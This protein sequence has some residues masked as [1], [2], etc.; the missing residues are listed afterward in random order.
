MPLI[1][2]RKKLAPA[3]PVIPTDD[4]GARL[5]VRGDVGVTYAT[6]ALTGWTNQVAGGWPNG[7]QTNA[8]RRPTQSTLNGRNCPL[9]AG[10]D[11]SVNFI[12]MNVALPTFTI[13]I[14]SYMTSVAA[15]QRV[16]LEMSDDFAFADRGAQVLQTTTRREGRQE[17]SAASNAGLTFNTANV[18]VVDTFTCTATIGVTPA[19]IS[20]YRNGVFQQQQNQPDGEGNPRLLQQCRIGANR[21][22]AQGFVGYLSD[23]AIWNNVLAAPR[24]LAQANAALARWS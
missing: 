19:S 6:G 15:A 18:L 5:W 8:A 24:L 2:G 4:A 16:L 21:S 1:L 12:G 14:V 22:N 20:F 13:Q 9:W 7:T 23:I 11:D 10:T 3:V 17:Y